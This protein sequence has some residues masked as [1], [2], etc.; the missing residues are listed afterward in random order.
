M[1][2]TKFVLFYYFI[3]KTDSNSIIM[4]L[5]SI[6]KH[7]STNNFYNANANRATLNAVFRNLIT[8]NNLKF[9]AEKFLEEDDAREIL[10]PIIHETLSILLNEGISK[11]EIIDQFGS[12]KSPEIAVVGI[13]LLA[14]DVGATKSNSYASKEQSV[15]DCAARAFVGMELH[16]GFWSSFTNKKSCVPISMASFAKA[17]FL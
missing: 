11:S 9:K 3:L 16:E 17:C 6:Y 10:K 1:Q 15:L 5:L 13:V 14:E 2:T 12:L 8:Q 4:L 7:D